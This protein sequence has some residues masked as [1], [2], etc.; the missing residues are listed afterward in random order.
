MRPH[1]TGGGR[2]AF[3]M[4]SEE[5][6]FACCGRSLRL[7]AIQWLEDQDQ[8][9]GLSMGL[10]EPSSGV[11][12]RTDSQGLAICG[13]P[14]TGSVQIAF[15]GARAVWTPGDADR[16]LPRLETLSAREPGH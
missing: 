2:V 3:W 6:F 1:P 10:L 8:V 13:Q 11:T 4:V 16:I 14:R 9:A 15:Y 12:F 7:V 5:A